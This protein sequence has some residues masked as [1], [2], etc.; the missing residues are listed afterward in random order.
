M[1]HILVKGTN[2]HSVD[3]NRLTH[4]A[5]VFFENGTRGTYF[6]VSPDDAKLLENAE[7]PGGVLHSIFKLKYKYE[8]GE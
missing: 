6:G 3:Y 7:S 5:E 4:T 1:S 2:V 8:R